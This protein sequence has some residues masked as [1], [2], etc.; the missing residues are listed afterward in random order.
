MEPYEQNGDLFEKVS[1]DFDYNWVICGDHL[2]EQ[3]CT[4]GIFR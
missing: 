4:G 3:K 1:D 2:P